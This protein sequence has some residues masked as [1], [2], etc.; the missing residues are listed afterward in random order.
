MR[1]IIVL[2]LLLLAGTSSAQE[3]DSFIELLRSDVRTD[4]VEMITDAMEFTEAEATAFWPAYRTY[5]F[6]LEE[7]GDTY[8]AIIKD[9]A[10]NSESLTDE[11]AKDLTERAFAYKESRL[12]LQKKYF[13]EFSK[14][15]TPIKAARWAQLENQIGLLIELQVISEIPLAEAPANN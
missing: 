11:K 1:R 15:I 10:A 3:I 13:K 2:A 14:L 9:Y 12:K 5:Q 7:L 8:V 4:K 6:E